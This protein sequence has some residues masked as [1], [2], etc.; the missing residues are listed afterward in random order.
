VAGSDAAFRESAAADKLI[1]HRLELILGPDVASA[2]WILGAWVPFA[3][4]LTAETLLD[5]E[6]MREIARGIHDALGVG[7]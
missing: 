4:R 7:P 6:A 5:G 1:R 3:H 2:A